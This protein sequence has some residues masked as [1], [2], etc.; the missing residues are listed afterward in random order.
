MRKKILINLLLCF[1][2]LATGCTGFTASR[3]PLLPVIA[4]T[5]G[6][7]D[8]EISPEKYTDRDIVV[9]YPQITQLSDSDKQQKI[10]QIIKT[11][12]LQMLSRYSADELDKLSIN[13]DYI[14]KYQ[15]EDLLSV[16]YVGQRYLQGTPYPVRVFFS[17]NIDIREGRKVRLPDVAVIDAGFVEKVQQGNFIAISPDIT[18][19]MLRLTDDKIIRAFSAADSID[20]VENKAGAYSYFTNE[21]LGVGLSVAHV[22]GDQV[23]FEM[24]YPVIADSIKAVQD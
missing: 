6:P 8:Y 12:A 7:A 15:S 13:I 10:N 1:V 21:S 23:L 14:I 17:T 19:K 11:E 2:I 4:V 3:N 24:K 22:L 16:T 20:E 9:K 18:I 5:S